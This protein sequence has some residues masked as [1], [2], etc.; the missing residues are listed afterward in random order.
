[1]TRTLVRLCLALGFAFFI[2][3]VISAQGGGGGGQPAAPVILSVQPNLVSGVLTIIGT[4]FGTSAPTVALEGNALSVVSFSNTQVVA[5]IPSLLPKAYLLSLTKGGTT[6]NVKFE[7]GIESGDISA[8]VPGTGLSGGGSTGDVTL[9]VNTNAIQARVTG[10][11]A[12]G[13]SIRSIDGAGGVTCEPDDVGSGASLGPNTFTGTQTIDNGNLDLDP[14]TAT[15]GNITKNGT[16]FLHNF[17]INNTFLGIQAGQNTT[18]ASGNTAVGVSALQNATNGSSN[19]ALGFDALL[20]N[21][22]GSSNTAVGTNAM[23]RNQTGVENTASGYLAMD[24]NT[25]GSG[26]TAIGKAALQSANGDGNTAVGHHTMAGGATSF[27]GSAN[28][29]MGLQALR[30]VTSGNNNT[31]TGYTALLFNSGGSSNTAIGSGALFNNI[32]GTDNVALGANAGLNATIGSNNIYLGAN[33]LGIAGESNT[34]YL[35]VQGTQ[36]KTVIAGIRGTAVSGG[37]PVVIDANGRLG[38]GAVAPSANSVGSNEVID[39]SLTAN[40]LAPNSV[41]TSE[42]A[43][44]SVNFDKVAFNYAG[45]DS[46]GG[47]A[48]DVACLACI[49]AGEVNFT[50]ASLGANTFQATQRIGTGNLDLNASTSTGG[51]ITK[52]GTPFLHNFGSN[53]VFLGEAAGNLSMTGD[54]NTAIGWRTL[55]N[56]T[57]GVRNTAIGRIA[58]SAN[59][60][61]NQNTA[62]GAG[63]LASNTIGSLNVAVGEQALFSSIS[64]GN[65]IAVGL[66]ALANHSASDNNIAIGRDA[67][68]NLSSGAGNIAIGTFAGQFL[69]SGSLNLYIAN[70]GIGNESNTIRI[71]QVQNRA[72]INGIR[73]VTTGLAD[74]IPVVI[75]SAGQLGTISSSRR[76]K[77]DIRDMADAS[78]RLFE[79]RPVT[80]RY[81][82]T[83]ADGSKPIQYGLIAEE[84]AQVFP[85][86]AVRK[87][88]GDVETVHYETLNVLLLN[89]VQRQEQ[90]IRDQEHRIEVLEREVQRLLHPDPH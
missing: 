63:A 88:S 18:T 61:G 43:P 7:L 59:S 44:N 53:N 54:G 1:M 16:P 73:S 10:V 24:E 14:S 2:G 47:P 15:T 12:A 89:E 36:T 13:S 81:K 50:F 11:C 55:Q 74:A 78:K 3:T 32:T 39:D 33:A 42:L 19:T 21:G 34:I 58:L 6:L 72:F 51:N 35:G 22:S 5:A 75:D 29:A 45:S 4:G 60:G 9:S 85:E 27:T 65:S 31:A 87:A 83:Y 17:G 62:V 86:L 80:F 41:T 20:S 84:V 67:A 68:A 70:E 52:N 40:D 37:Q 82:E 79:L 8:V 30:E 28:T 38:S 48:L 49:S 64:G 57:Q 25:T 71:G 69:N 56:N 23:R 90:T 26:N 46:E 76:Y 66:R 77:E